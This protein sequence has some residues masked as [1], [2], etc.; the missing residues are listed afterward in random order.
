[1]KKS[2]LINLLLSYEE[3]DVFIECD[4]MEHEI[5]VE[6]VDEVFDG[7]DE[8]FPAHLILKKGK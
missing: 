3:E 2:E 5:E 7:F 6:V 4:E 1:M 8:V